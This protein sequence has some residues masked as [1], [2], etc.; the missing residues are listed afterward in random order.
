AVAHGRVRGVR[1]GGRRAERLPD[2]VAVHRPAGAETLTTSNGWLPMLVN[3]NGSP[4]SNAHTVP[5]RCCG[6]S[7]LA[8]PVVNRP[9]PSPA[10]MNRLGPAS[11]KAGLCSSPPRS[12]RTVVARTYLLSS[13]RMTVA[14]LVAGGGG[15]LITAS[16]RRR[17]EMNATVVFDALRMR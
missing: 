8:V 6:K 14:P 13:E 5:A 15:G 7:P 4:G 16:L 11:A 3:A 2:D 1:T 17:T 9:A 10:R 12:T